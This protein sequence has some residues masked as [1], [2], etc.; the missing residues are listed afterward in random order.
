MTII[1]ELHA[2]EILDSR[3]F[4]TVEVDCVLECGARG[5]AAVPS[6]ASTGVHEALELRD[7][8]AKRYRGKGVTTAVHNVGEKIAPEIVGADALDQLWIDR[9]L[10]EIDGTENK[11]RLGANA[12]LGV[13]LAVSK[14]AAQA[15]GLPLYRYIGGPSAHLLPV[16]LMNVLNGGKHADWNTDLQE[17][18]IVPAGASSFREGLRMGAEVFHALAGVLKDK[19]YPVTVGD[20]GGFAPPLKSNEEALQLIMRAIEKAGYKPGTDVYL[21]LDP[22]A[23]EFFDKGKYRLKTEKKPLKS[24]QEMVDFYA[25][26]VKKYPLISIEDGLAQDDWKG[27]KLL[28]DRVGAR[29]QIVGDDLFVT[30]VTRLRRGIQTGTANSILIKLNQIGTLSETLDCITA[31]HRAGYTAVVSHRSGETEDTTISDL[32]VATNAGQIKTG[33]LSRTDRLAKYNQLLRI[34]EELG[35]V[36]AYAGL[37]AFPRYE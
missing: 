9:R 10:L 27:W 22:A 3:G 8:D 2:R 23:S 11:S 12:T 6:G 31:A 5:R 17:F 28:T 13:S 32:V 26:W 30:N 21:A 33:S 15:L 14:A 4:P 36:A 34:E 37:R 18:M 25:A 7:G 24:A 35:S 20:E 29:V 1:T 16:P 19:S